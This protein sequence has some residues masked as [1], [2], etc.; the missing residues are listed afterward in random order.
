M[1]RLA[2]SA[3]DVH[4]RVGLG[5]CRFTARPGEGKEWVS[6]TYHDPTDRRPI[7]ILEEET[8]VT[9]TE[10]E[11]S[12]ERLGAAFGGVPRYELK[13]GKERPFA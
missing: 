12:F 9:I 2:T 3:G 8:G 4:L 1:N 13:F 5:A 10:A 7:R 11:P 6:E